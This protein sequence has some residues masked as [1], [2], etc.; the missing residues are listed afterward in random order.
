MTVNGH[1][2]L[3]CDSN[4]HWCPLQ[5]AWALILG[6]WVFCGHGWPLHDAKWQNPVLLD[7]GVRYTK[8][9]TE[10][11]IMNLSVHDMKQAA[12]TLSNGPRHRN[13]KQI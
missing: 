12:K 7:I 5:R 13:T 4:G 3:C 2:S 10:T 9:M 1:F 11:R 8:Q 6:F